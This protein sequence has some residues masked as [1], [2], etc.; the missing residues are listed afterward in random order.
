VELETLTRE[1]RATIIRS[2][3]GDWIDQGEHWPHQGGGVAGL[4]K[5]TWQPALPPN[6]G[7]TDPHPEF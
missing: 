6:T 7:L 2:A 1:R 3:R 4:I 5:A